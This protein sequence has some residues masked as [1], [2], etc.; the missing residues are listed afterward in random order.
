[1]GSGDQ[2]VQ[3]ALYP[4]PPLS[5]LVDTCED[6]WEMD[7]SAASQPPLQLSAQAFPP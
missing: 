5:V 7:G 1:M 3:Q 2:F 4:I 6:F